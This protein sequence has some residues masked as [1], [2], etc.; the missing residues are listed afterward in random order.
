MRCYGPAMT[1]PQGI[2]DYW[3]ETDGSQQSVETMAGTRGKVLKDQAV[4]EGLWP[5][6]KL[7]ADE[8]AYGN[9]GAP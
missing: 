7:T 1:P 4:D 8:K 9:A 5:P 3:R 6:R 2:Q